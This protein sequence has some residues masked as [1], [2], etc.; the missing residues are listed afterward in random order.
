MKLGWLMV[1][2]FETNVTT[3]CW[4]EHLF[5]CGANNTGARTMDEIAN[6]FQGRGIYR[7]DEEY[8]TIGEA[9]EEYDLDIIGSGKTRVV[10]ELPD[11]WSYGDTDCIAKIQWDPHYHQTSAEIH[12]WENADGRVAA[13]LAPVL[14]SSEMRNWLIMPK[15]EMYQDLT[16][17]ETGGIVKKLRSELTKLGVKSSDIRRANVGRIAGRDVVIDYGNLK[18]G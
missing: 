12:T 5:N 10:I 14:D 11:K 13:L 4:D 17:K 2:E 18:L 9:E 1:V 16:I 3:E 7:G 8:L 6:R 15:A